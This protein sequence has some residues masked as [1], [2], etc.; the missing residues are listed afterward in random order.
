[1]DEAPLALLFLLLIVL[2]A[3]AAF[4][5]SAETAMMSLNRY[6]LK[7]L[8]N[9]GLRSARRASWL[10]KRPD[11]LL[12]FILIGNT[13]VNIFAAAIATVIG[14][15]LLGGG[16]FAVT[17]SGFLLTLALLIFGELTPKTIAALY[18]ERIAFPLSHILKPLLRLSYPLV[19]LINGITNNLLRLVGIN[20]AKR[21]E[22]PLSQAEL[23]TIVN[24]A[25]QL[26]P[27][28]HQGMLINIL[29]L[30]QMTIEDVMV[31][32]N[33][34]VGLDLGHDDDALLAQL[35]ECRFT[36][37][38]VY[39]GDINNIVGMLHLRAGARLLN[40]AG[41]L[42]RQALTREII[43]PYFV[44]EGTPLHTQLLNFQK[45]KRRMAI[46]VDEYGS[47]Q[48]LV[49]LEDILEEIVG[50]FTSNLGSVS[51]DI[52]AEDDGSHLIDGGVGIREI[53]R[54]LEWNLPTDGPKTL[55]GL[56]LEHLEAFP[57]GP[58]CLRIGPY[59][60]ETQSAQGKVLKQV[61]VIRTTAPAPR[62]DEEEF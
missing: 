17:L 20:P 41:G 62:P 61:R 45:D 2:I 10:L 22:Q 54:A 57:D 58:V 59:Q 1:V 5:A 7:H 30:E 16:G 19:L 51:E 50:E 40:T 29:D 23:R 55:N 11:R 46:V 27:E 53:N 60:F 25:G 56:V 3:L 21:P 35:R 26:I 13:L 49:A 32:R 15:R 44:P 42:D 38:P 4:F 48:G 12:G 24:E 39:E 6:R 9:S 33:E 47:V 14:L 28:R 31:P 37:L 8:A 18:P 34:I 52:R 36:R 43:A